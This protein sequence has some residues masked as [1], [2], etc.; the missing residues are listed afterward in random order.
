MICI[1]CGLELPSKPH[2]RGRPTRFHNATCRQRAHRAG[3]A[4]QHRDLLSALS[5]VE[6]T[7]SELRRAVLSGEDL[8]GDLGHRLRETTGDVLR[9]LDGGAP[10]QEQIVTENVT[11]RAPRRRTRTTPARNTV[12]DLESVRLE[13]RAEGRS[14]WRVLAGSSEEPI[15][16]GFLEPDFSRTTGRRNGRWH[17]LTPALIKVSGGPWRNRDA[18]MVRLVDSYQRIASNQASSR[19]KE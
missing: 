16:V 8:A 2:G 15:L 19:Y 1:G 10:P 12:L 9:Q 18:A 11:E 3:I 17:A 13:R 6:S 5:T 4:T 14:G 7:I